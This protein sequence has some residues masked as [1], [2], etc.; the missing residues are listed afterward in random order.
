MMNLAIL[1]KA[2]ENKI[3]GGNIYVKARCKLP[4][5]NV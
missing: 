5:F 3:S 1:R 2:E 4:V